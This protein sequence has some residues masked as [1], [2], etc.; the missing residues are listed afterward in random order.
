MNNICPMFRKCTAASFLRKRCKAMWLALAVAALPVMARPDLAPAGQPALPQTQ[1]S[2]GIHLIHAEIAADEAT[3]A[4]GLMF[5][6]SLGTSDG[7]LFVFPRRDIQCFW[8]RNTLIALSAAF[9]D[10]DGTVVNIADMT[11]LTDTPHCSQQ[12]VRYVLEMNQGWFA[13]RGI[14]AQSV[15]AGLP[16]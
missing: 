14:V 6:Q 5:R 1:L 12:A 15:I 2:A 7:M 11:P 13:Q 10:D 4:R 8:M 9:L 3:R 16:K